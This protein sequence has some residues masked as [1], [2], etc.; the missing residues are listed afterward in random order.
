MSP[1]NFTFIQNSTWPKYFIPL[2][3][4][5]VENFLPLD[6]IPNIFTAIR[7]SVKIFVPLKIRSKKTDPLRS[8][9]DSKG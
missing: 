2:K 3:I 6:S 5:L 4:Y 8:Y 9:Q 1:G 7:F